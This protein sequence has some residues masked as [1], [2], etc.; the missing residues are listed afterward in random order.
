MIGNF[1]STIYQLFD[2]YRT[3]NSEWTG[4]SIQVRIQWKIKLLFWTNGNAGLVYTPNT[5]TKDGLNNMMQANYLG[6]FLLTRLLL[7]N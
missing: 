5:V 4:R 3:I 1:F 2:Q 7:D 6:H